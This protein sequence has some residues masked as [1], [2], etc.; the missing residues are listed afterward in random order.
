[1]ANGNKR[2][3]EDPMPERVFLGV[4]PTL[5]DSEDEEQ[6]RRLL[7]AFFERGIGAKEG[8][9]GIG[10]H[11]AGALDR[12]AWCERMRHPDEWADFNTDVRFARTPELRAANVYREDV[13]KLE[14][15]G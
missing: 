10:F 4:S 1:M 13:K 12:Y 3:S 5:V 6:V 8:S 9:D 15:F 2:Y 11:Y 14:G 7:K